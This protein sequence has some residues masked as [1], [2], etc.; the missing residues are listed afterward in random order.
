MFEK[1]IKEIEENLASIKEND[2]NHTFKVVV[3]TS[4]TDR[5]GEVINQDWI[6]LKEYMKNPVVLVNHD[7]R[8]ESIIW[9]ATKVWKEWNKT[10][11]EWVFSQT[12][13]KAKLV[14]DLYNEW[15]LKAVSIWFIPVERK[16]G[17]TIMK[18]NMLEFS[19][20]AVP[21]NPEALDAM[22]KELVQKWIEAWLLIEEIKEEEKVDEISLKDIMNEIKLLNDKVDGITKSFADDKVKEEEILDIKAKKEALQSIDRSIGEAL[23]QIKF[24]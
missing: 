18:S 3:S 24:L 7:Y 15:M 21:C 10:Y 2:T 16:N 11:A 6:D 20:V 13:P 8:V 9:K 17:D 1:F 23:K 22:G 4:T 19:F 14:Q 12:N 5:S